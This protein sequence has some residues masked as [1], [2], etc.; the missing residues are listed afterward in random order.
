MA[1][2]RILIA[3]SAGFIG[4]HIAN[5]LHRLGYVI[6]GVD[7]LSGG[8][9]E[10]MNSD[11]VFSQ[12]ELSARD[13]GWIF[14]DF[15]PEIVYHLAAN[16]R[17]GASFYQPMSIV[18][19]N[20]MAYTNVLTM[21]IKYNVKR[22][23]LFSSMS[24]Y[25]GQEPPFTEDMPLDPIDIYGLQKAN[26]EMMTRMLYSS[27]YSFDYVIIR[28]HN[29][30]GKNQAFDIHRNVIAI[31]MN[32]IARGEPVTIYGDGKQKRAFSSIGNSLPAFIKAMKAPSRR[33]FNIGGGWP[34]QIN[35][36]AK[37]VIEAMGEDP[38]KYPI[39][40]LPGRHA[41]VKEAYT[42]HDNAERYL[43]FVPDT[44]E[45]VVEGIRKMAKWAK[46]VLPQEWETADPLE[47]PNEHTT[48]MW[49]ND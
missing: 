9:R 1:R 39:E 26:M 24:V 42:S 2:T 28:P 25:G 12:V 21:A 35:D 37:I 27:H 33:I 43:D 19:R 18:R 46:T 4:S 15:K 7:D 5:E 47:I 29:V 31:W 32:K 6:Y 23:I 17:E 11:I 20:M 38:Q 48:R 16:A 22:V 13:I 44:E 14:D 34:A 8:S 41:E 3:G 10:N 30:F 40:Y 36:I 45:Q 49:L